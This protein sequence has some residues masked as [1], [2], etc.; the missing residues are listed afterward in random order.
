[1]RFRRLSTACPS[2]L[3]L[4]LW[5][6][7]A[8]SGVPGNGGSIEERTNDILLH[9][10][11]EDQRIVCEEREPGEPGPYT[12][13]ECEADG[14]PPEC[15]AKKVPSTRIAGTMVISAD[16]DA[17]NNPVGDIPV[18]LDYKFRLN[19]KG[20][21]Y[22]IVEE[23]GPGTAI[24][25]WNPIADEVQ[26]F[27]LIGEG[28]IMDGT[29]QTFADELTRLVSEWIERNTPGDLPPSVPVITQFRRA[30]S[31]RDTDRSA[32]DDPLGSAASYQVIFRFYEIQP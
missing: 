14:L 20:R 13:A 28:Q 6:S 25:N 31:R 26:I 18:T 5:V 10:C 2:L 7:P 32:P 27:G 3:A 11:S 8:W 1:M 30:E 29:L 19:G 21:Q 23:F 12:G 4:L 9:V 24:G 22:R 17:P 15:V 16:D